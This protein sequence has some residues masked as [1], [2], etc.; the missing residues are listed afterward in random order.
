MTLNE[1]E[2]EE[3]KKLVAE[4]KELATREASGEYIYRVRAYQGK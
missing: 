3:C 4:A 1:S 2:R